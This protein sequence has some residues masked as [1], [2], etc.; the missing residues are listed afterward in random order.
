MSSRF[1][2]EIQPRYTEVL[3]NLLRNES[4]R[5][6]ID[7]AL[8][9]YPIYVAVSEHKYGIPNTIPTR[10]ELNKKILDFY[11]YREIAFETPFRFFDELEIAMNEIMPRYNQLMFS[12]DQDYDIKFNVDYKKTIERNRDLSREGKDTSSSTGNNTANAQDTQTSNASTETNTKNVHSETPQNDI[13]VANTGIDQVSY[14]DDI[15]WNKANGS[16][17]G[18]S[19]G[20]SSSSSNS[21]LSGTTNS[22]GKENEDETSEERTFGNYGVVSAQDLIMKYRDTILNIEQMI[23]E[24]PRIAELFMQVY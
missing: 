12:A 1:Y 23:I 19:T 14:A 11:K 20:T 21:T 4:T 9:S 17:S 7:Q 6:L 15:T 16:D 22:E 18:T 3:Y 24:D 13:S 5:P 10:E 8:S 2:D